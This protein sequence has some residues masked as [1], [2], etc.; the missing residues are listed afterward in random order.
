MSERLVKVAPVLPPFDAE[1]ACPKCGWAVVSV[2]H[3]ENTRGCSLGAVMETSY[4]PEHLHRTCGRCFYG[5][6]EDVLQPALNDRGD[7]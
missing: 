1:A 3:H 2:R 4:G 7:Q 5:W 6:N